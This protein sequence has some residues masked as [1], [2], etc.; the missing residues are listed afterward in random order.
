MR[1]PL[2]ETRSV[3]SG[4]TAVG[5]DIG[6]TNCKTAL[7][8]A[9][10]RV[11]DH[12]SFAI[13]QQAGI[14]PFL[15]RLYGSVDRVAGAVASGIGALLPGYLDAAR[16]VPRIMVNIPMLEGVPLHGHLSARYGLPVALDI[17]RNG[18]AWAEHLFNHTDVKRLMYVTIG[19]GVG[20]GMTVSGEILRVCNDSI[21]ELGHLTLEPGG[22]PCT[23]GNL[24]CVETLVSKRGLALI[25]N[26][27]GI[28]KLADKPVSSGVEPLE[29]YRSARAGNGPARRVFEQ[30]AD[31]LGA[32]LVT[33][34]NT[35]SP[36]LIVVGGG[37]A[38]AADLFLPKAEAWLN[39]HWFEKKSKAIRLVRSGFG[40]HAGV[41]GAASLVL[42]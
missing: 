18:P 26:R 31:Y 3:N 6:G 4:G 16:T 9:G 33:Y 22:V 37:I 21:G 7:V 34:A 13:D 10:G 40:E 35:F 36:D 25:A 20:V 11:L 28:E 14:D 27:L 39:R 5:I 17:D 41:I 12:H 32:A 15:D 29:V 38:G 42:M 19:T 2:A 30:F 1:R 8:D 23:C 24:G